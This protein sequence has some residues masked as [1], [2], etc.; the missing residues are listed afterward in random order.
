LAVEPD[1]LLM[2]EPCSALDPTSTRRVEETIAELRGRLTIVIVTHN[3][4]QAQRVSQSCAFFLATHDTPGRIVEAGPT[5]Q[6]FTNPVD[7]RTA[8]YVN[9]RFG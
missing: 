1:I 6:L 7:S 9:G 2:D 8:D 4:Q 5:E 3:M